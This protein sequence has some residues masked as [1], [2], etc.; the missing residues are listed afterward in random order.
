M[1]VVTGANGQLGR[2]VIQHLIARGQPAAGIVAAVRNPAKAADLAALGV[3]L[4]E[5]DYD[6]PDTLAGALAGAQ[7]V[8]LISSSEIGQRLPQHRAVIEAA[9]AAGAGQLA[10][11]SLLHADSSPL[12]L[13]AE[14]T[15]TEALI[16]ASG[17]RH[18]ILR[19]GWYAENHLASVAAALQHGAL[20]GA[21]GAGRIAWATRSDYAE[22]AAAVLLQPVGADRVLELAGDQGH[23]LAELAA[24][25]G[26]QAGRALPYVDLPQAEFEAALLGAGLP[27]PLA[28][29]LADSDAGAALG[30]LADDSRTL[31][32]L[33]GRPTTPL[34]AAVAAAL[35]PA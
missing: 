9:R 3:Q 15:A 35:A 30:G 13:A 31:G 10:Y 27:A 19:N 21:A 7:R 20:I 26:R 23:T 32:T 29:L 16:R 33:I 25:I 5:A 34:A 28:A 2:L 18:V 6:R 12:A 1:I 24:E 17:L 14:H 11:T 22:A 8:L 4:R